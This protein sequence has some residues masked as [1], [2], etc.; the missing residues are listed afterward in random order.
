MDADK[1]GHES[2]PRQEPVL[3]EQPVQGL[4][5]GVPLIDVPLRRARVD[6][7]REFVPNLRVPTE[8]QHPRCAM[9]YFISAL[10]KSRLEPC[11]VSTL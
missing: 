10:K 5:E 7:R 9:Q 11:R 4:H 1:S 2:V 6:V 3:L 8:R